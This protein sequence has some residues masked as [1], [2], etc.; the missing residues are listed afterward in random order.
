[1]IGW[2]ARIGSIQPSRGDTFTY[3]F[4]KMAPEGVVLVTTSTNIKELTDAEFERALGEYEQA[5]KILATE[6]VDFIL[7]GGTP[8]I[9]IKGSGADLAIAAKIQAATGIPSLHN[10]TA[11]IESLRKLNIRKIAV[12]TPYRDAVNER[13]KRFLEANGFEVV[14]IKWMQIERNVEIAKT[15]PYAAYRLAKETFREAEG[16][17]GIYISCSR[18]QTVSFI[19]ALEQDLKVP[20]VSNSLSSIWAA[21]ARTG[22]GEAKPGFGQLMRS[23]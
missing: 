18:W 6:E 5:G 19:E 3:E 2:R 16:A 1:M 21:F 13:H 11:V 7:V 12:A 23:L 22:V 9:A 8:V 15:P 10:F 4:Y 17:E 14:K 20:V